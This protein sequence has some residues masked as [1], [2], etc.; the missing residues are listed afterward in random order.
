MA[1][2][3]SEAR[4]VLFRLVGPTFGDEHTAIVRMREKQARVI[5]SALRRAEARGLRRA[6]EI[7]PELLAGQIR[8]R[9]DALEKAGGER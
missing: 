7:M 3:E 6:A 1:D 2:H 9:A 8:R 4:E 5:A